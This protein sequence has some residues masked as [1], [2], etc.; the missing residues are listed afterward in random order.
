MDRRKVPSQGSPEGAFLDLWQHCDHC[1]RR[2]W[3]GEKPKR[4]G[5]CGVVVYC[6]KECQRAA[7][8]THR[9]L[10]RSAPEKDTN[11]SKELGYATPIAL[12]TALAEWLRIHTWSLNTIVDA[13][14]YLEG[15]ID[16]LLSSRPPAFFMAVAPRH[17]TAND[18]NPAEAFEIVG[19]TIMRKG[20]Y[21]AL[22]E[23][24]NKMEAHCN[25]VARQL[26][27]QGLFNDSAFGGLLPAMYLIPKLG[28]CVFQA[29]AILRLPIQHVKDDPLDE[30]TRTAFRE[31]QEVV[32]GA[33]C[34]G[35][36]VY[37]CATNPAQ[38]EPDLGMFA[39][40]KKARKWRHLG[41][42]AWAHFEKFV[43]TQTKRKTDVPPRSLLTLFDTRNPRNAALRLA[44]LTVKDGQL[45]F[46][47]NNPITVVREFI[48]VDSLPTLM[49][50]DCGGFYQELH[51]RL[52]PS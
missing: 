22:Q 6:D 9:L 36:L 27:A 2:N 35:A 52:Q 29:H 21:P 28:M 19:R 20:D 48:L 34:H 44:P 3:G 42:H 8:Q 24:W 37:R 16:V 18:G 10:C 40:H 26:R 51:P 39:R 12:A 49:M 23:L 14:V 50:T 7:W 31:L 5:G 41:P 46:N 4:C 32:M 43:R 13:A 11:L 45:V 30:H 17:A 47:P 25:S 33:I 15:G 1:G 38:A